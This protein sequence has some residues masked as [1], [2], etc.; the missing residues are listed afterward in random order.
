M[1]QD[2]KPKQN[3]NAK[4]SIV[5][6]EI[7]GIFQMPHTKIETS[8]DC[9]SV[10]TVRFRAHSESSAFVGLHCFAA[11]LSGS[12]EHADVRTCNRSVMFVCGLI[13]HIWK[14]HQCSSTFIAFL[15]HWIARRSNGNHVKSTPDQTRNAAGTNMR[16]KAITQTA[17]LPRLTVTVRVVT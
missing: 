7:K 14:T 5:Q 13:I 17:R 12:R 3:S 4:F 15:F 16:S 11:P 8:V 9:P 10:F 6:N 1:F 2:R